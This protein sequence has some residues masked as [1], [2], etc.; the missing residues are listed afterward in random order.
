MYNLEEVLSSNIPPTCGEAT[1]VKGL[2]K[3]EATTLSALFQDITH[4]ENRLHILCERYCDSRAKVQRYQA[5]LSPVRLL[6]P[7]LVRKIFLFCIGN[8]PAEAP[9]LPDTPP[10][11]LTQICSG[12]REV[13][14]ATSELWKNITFS[15][16]STH[17]IANFKNLAQLWLNR[18][19]TIPATLTFSL[20][21]QPSVENLLLDVVAPYSTS[22]EALELHLDTALFAA[23][24][25]FPPEAFPRLRSIRFHGTRVESH[26]SRGGLRLWDPVT[27]PFQFA[28]QLTD[29]LITIPETKI[30][31]EALNLPWSQLSSL[32]LAESIVTSGAFLR[33][34]AAC[35]RLVSC[36]VRVVTEEAIT[37]AD[38]DIT[39][40]FLTSLS[41]FVEA[42][43]MVEVLCNISTPAIKSL[44]LRVVPHEIWYPDA[45]IQLVSRSGCRLEHLSVSGLTADREGFIALLNELPTLLTLDVMFV[46]FLSDC[47]LDFMTPM[48]I[49]EVP[50]LPLLKVM[51]WR[52]IS[53]QCSPESIRQFIIS[54]GWPVV[55]EQGGRERP[56]M[57]RLESLVM[58]STVGHFGSA[59]TKNLEEFRY[60]GLDLCYG[61]H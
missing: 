48:S 3:G 47:V 32:H 22:I 10:L 40:T 14:L 18:C 29:V 36:S 11:S 45:L 50:I 16:N 51:K 1:F 27:V 46:S 2:L 60:R 15:G 44:S 58:Q 57:N 26:P 24:A 39:L 59:W 56:N 7:E 35:S 8:S 34:L 21:C 43:S 5:V 28:P 25:D 12:W 23:F 37:P 54:R 4:L 6:P 52:E 13:A 61:V 55:G 20:N 42:G 17:G 53:L 19:H 9:P 49:Y 38:S 31:L 33:V 30:N 41:L